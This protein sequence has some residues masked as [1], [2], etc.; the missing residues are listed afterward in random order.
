MVGE[1]VSF[2][3]APSG[4]D[5]ADLKKNDRSSIAFPYLDLDSAIEVAKAVYER[6]GLSGCEIDEL[7]AQMGQRVSGAF[8]L[9][10]STAKLFDLL[11]R[12]GRGALKLSS[13]G[14][15]IVASETEAEGR[16]GAFFSIPLYK[17]IFERY[18]GRL[19]PPQKALER[20]MVS[21]GVAPKQASKARQA[22]ER[23]ARQAGFCAQGDDRLV[24]PR[25]DREV[26]Q[27][28]IDTGEAADPIAR[29]DELGNGGGG[30]NGGP[31]SIDK[32]LEYHLID[33][34]KEPAIEQEE[35]NAVWTLVQ[36]LTRN[37]AKSLD[38]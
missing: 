12:E 34:L 13:L 33:L 32:P 18:R 16:A 20:E 26:G 14:Q 7:A 5:E 9:K 28:K 35:R 30:G 8:R 29:D 11:D 19:L 22:F 3:R 1:R 25:F 36:F 17:A 31:P 24:A 23:S 27:R 38:A 4:P 15:K 6:A 2:E 21:L 10:T 37:R